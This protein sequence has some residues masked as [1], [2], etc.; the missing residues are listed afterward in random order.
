MLIPR[1]VIFETQGG[2]GGG[3]G[4]DKMDVTEV[5]LTWSEVFT[6]ALVCPID[7]DYK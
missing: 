7:Q 1:D 6:Y 2:G 3:V 5:D 4:G